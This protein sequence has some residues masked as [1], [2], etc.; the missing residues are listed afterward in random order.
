MAHCDLNKLALEILGRMLG[1]ESSQVPLTFG[2]PKLQELLSLTEY[3]GIERFQFVDGNGKPSKRNLL[4]W[5]KSRT[6][7]RK[8]SHK[9]LCGF[10][11]FAADMSWR[12]D[13]VKLAHSL[14]DHPKTQES[15]HLSTFQGQEHIERL[16]ALV[17]QNPYVQNQQGQVSVNKKYGVIS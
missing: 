12:G 15:V 8:L 7:G 6:E 2:D 16:R 4:E 5:L 9:K 14:L 17:T 13:F 11:E 10:A 3:A 1:P